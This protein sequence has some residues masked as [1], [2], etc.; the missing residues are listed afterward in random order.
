MWDSWSSISSPFHSTDS[1]YDVMNSGEHQLCFGFG[2]WRSHYHLIEW[3]FALLGLTHSYLGVDP[4]PSTLGLFRFL[5]F[6]WYLM[7]R[8]S[9]IAKTYS[10]LGFT[11]ISDWMACSSISSYIGSF[12]VFPHVDSFA[13]Y[14][15]HGLIWYPSVL[16]FLHGTHG[17]S[18]HLYLDLWKPTLSCLLL[19]KKGLGNRWEGAGYRI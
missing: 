7:G 11:W 1:T 5:G 16:Y 14:Y 18:L 19:W 3:C 12:N 15:N 2:P 17:F 4:T 13:L 8:S 9:I 6:S 10:G